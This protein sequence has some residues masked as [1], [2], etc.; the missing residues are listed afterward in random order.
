M[1]SKPYIEKEIVKAIKI[2]KKNIGIE[3][4]WNIGDNNIKIL[5]KDYDDL[6]RFIKKLLREN[7]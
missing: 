7:D 4:G 2:N 1:L 6:R 5:E 3:C